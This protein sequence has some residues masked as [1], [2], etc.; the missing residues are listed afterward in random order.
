MK[1]DFRAWERDTLERFARDAADE[2]RELK[3]K[4]KELLVAWRK[5]VIKN[6]KE[7]AQ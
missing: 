7:Q 1:T 4:L 6:Q 2:N 3:E 5:E